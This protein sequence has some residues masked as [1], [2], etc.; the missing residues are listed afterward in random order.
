MII[1]VLRIFFLFFGVVVAFGFAGLA[2]F[3]LA[4]VLSQR[5]NG[6]QP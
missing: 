3:Y 4:W 5:D 6:W 2:V 1:M